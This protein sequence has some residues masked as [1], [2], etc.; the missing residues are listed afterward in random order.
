MGRRYRHL[1][2]SSTTSNQFNVRAIGGIRFVT[3]GTG[4]SVDGQPMVPSLLTV[5]DLNHSNIVNVV[6]GSPVNFVGP[7]V[8]GATISGRRRG[9]L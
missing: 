6:N 3:G 2:F 4:V 8:Y 5:N 1:N 7:G 9:E